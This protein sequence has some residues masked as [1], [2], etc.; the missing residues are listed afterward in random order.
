MTL[1][2][3]N[4]AI[5]KQLVI[6]HAV[7]GASIV[8]RAGG[9]SVILKLGKSEKA[10]AAQR[11][12]HIRVWRSLDRCV[13]FMRDELGIAKIN[14]LDASHYA[15][16]SPTRQTRADASD[17]LR[18]A[19]EAAAHDRWFRGEVQKG[20]DDLAAGRIITH[21]EYK[22]HSAKRKAALKKRI[23]KQSRRA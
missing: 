23:E 13:A 2:T 14:E 20:L 17:R 1:E 5:A 15:A 12:K 21:E 8:G 16:E 3:V 19:H 22:A 11:S 18:H 6:E 7:R 9:W 4:T 10:L